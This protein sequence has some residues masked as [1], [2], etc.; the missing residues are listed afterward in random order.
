MQWDFD[1]EGRVSL[2][3][4]NGVP[5]MRLVNGTNLDPTPVNQFDCS[6]AHQYLGLWNSP[7]LSMQTN[8]EA[9]S[10]TARHYS[11]RLFKSGLSTFEVW[12]AYFACFLLAMVFTFAVCSITEAEL[13]TLKKAPVRAMPRRIGINCNTSH[14]IVF[15]S[16]LYGGLGFQHLF[17]DQGIAQLQ[18]LIRLLDVDWPFIVA[19]D[20]R[21]LVSPVG[22]SNVQY[23]IC[24]TLMVY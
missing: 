6:R 1:S 16:S 9:L 8:R 10:M 17:V 7:S 18:L 22:G 5:S 4:S 14:D 15:S 21:L 13:T 11:H 12:L 23:F 19:L 2:R 3:S 20:P 24:G